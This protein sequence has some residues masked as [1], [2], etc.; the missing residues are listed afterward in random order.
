MRVERLVPPTKN[1]DTHALHV[2]QRARP[3]R[4]AGHLYQAIQSRPRQRQRRRL[5]RDGDAPAA[6]SAASSFTSMPRP[7]ASF[8]TSPSRPPKISRRLA[9][10][11]KRQKAR[12]GFAQ[13]PDADRLAIIDENG[14]YIGEEY[15]LALCRQVDHAAKS[16]ACIAAAN[17]STSRMID[18][19]AASMRR[20]RDPHAGGRSQRRPGD[21]QR[22]TP[23]SAAKATAA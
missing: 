17:L 16:Q 11:V 2:K 1:G 14:T 9:D 5:R 10:E 18:D 12:V 22:T 4:C 13:D 19:I 23:S 7:T 3:R 21:A 15:S 6:S 20:A 8:R